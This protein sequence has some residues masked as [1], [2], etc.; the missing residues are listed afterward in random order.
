[1]CSLKKKKKKSP[2]VFLIYIQETDTKKGTPRQRSKP[3]FRFEKETGELAKE[4]KRGGQKE[5]QSRE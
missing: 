5:N 2:E 4:L 3:T 1:M